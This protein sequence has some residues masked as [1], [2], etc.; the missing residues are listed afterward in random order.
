MNGLSWSAPAGKNSALLFSPTPVH[1]DAD[2]AG[3][4]L[5]GPITGSGL[6]ACGTGSQPWA[7]A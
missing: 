5:A 1:V 3:F 4:D 6:Q 2:G 7:A